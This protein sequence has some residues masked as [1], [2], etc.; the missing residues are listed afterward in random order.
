MRAKGGKDMARGTAGLEMENGTEI[1]KVEHTEPLSHP[2]QGI[3][4]YQG[5]PW[6]WDS[7]KTSLEGG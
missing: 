1:S 6:G 4:S 2:G 7:T 3:L 5:W